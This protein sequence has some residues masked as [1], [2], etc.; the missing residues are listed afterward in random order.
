M[1]QTDSC[2][3]LHN[4]VL[5]YLELADNQKHLTYHEDR[6]E[7]KLDAIFYSI[8]ADTYMRLYLDGCGANSTWRER[9]LVDEV[10]KIE[11]ETP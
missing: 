2:K 4:L 10:V 9:E 11:R 8:K 3:E 1:H 5:V 7:D 6:M